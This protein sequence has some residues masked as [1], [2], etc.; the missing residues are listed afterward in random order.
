MTQQNEKNF[1]DI[2]ILF[3][4]TL[5]DIVFIYGD[6]AT[7]GNIYVEFT[8]H[9]REAWKDEENNQYN[10]DRSSETRKLSISSVKN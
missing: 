6:A 4:Q 2:I 8:D 1:S 5:N 7:F 3:K 10:F 9:C